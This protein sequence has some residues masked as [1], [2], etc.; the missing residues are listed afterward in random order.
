[1][2]RLTQAI[3]RDRLAAGPGGRYPGA[4]EAI[5]AASNPGDPT[6]PATWPGWARLLPHLLA[7][8]PAATDSPAL[9]QLACD[10]C[11]VPD[12]AAAIPAAAM[13][14]PATCTEHW[15]DR[16]GADDPDTLEHGAATWPGR[17]RALGR[18]EQ[19]RDLD[20]DTLTRRRRRPGRRPPRHPDLGQ[21]PRR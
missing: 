20:E 2:H 1:M 16:L 14:W 17:L 4:A 13:T 9:R 19:A 6:T 3:L 7:L 18:Y 8:D 15:R 11:L 21:Q 12:L 10:A 5:L